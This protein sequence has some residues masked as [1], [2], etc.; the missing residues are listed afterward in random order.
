MSCKSIKSI[1][2]FVAICIQKDSAAQDK[3]VFFEDQANGKLYIERNFKPAT[4]VGNIVT[5][6]DLKQPSTIAIRGKNYTYRSVEFTTFYHCTNYSRGI[7]YF[8][9]YE[10]QM[11]TGVRLGE[12]YIKLEDYKPFVYS[13][14]DWDRLGYGKR[15]CKKTWELWR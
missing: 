11:G 12:T 1:A 15:F 5:L 7:N 6:L 13:F 8:T 2:F 3:W 9:Y 4:D 10:N 14:S